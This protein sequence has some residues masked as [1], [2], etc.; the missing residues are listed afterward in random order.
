M[1]QITRRLSSGEN[2]RLIIKVGSISKSGNYLIY[3][4]KQT[5]KHTSLLI[6]IILGLSI[7]GSF[8][9]VSSVYANPCTANTCPVAI[10]QPVNVGNNIIF[11]RD[12]NSM[13]NSTAN[14][15]LDKTSYLVADTAT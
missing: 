6:A 7:F 3:G 11:F 1:N 4:F 8:S 2:Q 12:I 9:L 5:S 14:S 10:S 13:D 15:S